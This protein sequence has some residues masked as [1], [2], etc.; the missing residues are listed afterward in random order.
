MVTR[1]RETEARGQKAVTDQE[2]VPPLVQVVLCQA[3]STLGTR[4]GAGCTMGKAGFTMARMDHWK[5]STS[6]DSVFVAL[7]GLYAAV[8]VV[9]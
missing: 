5:G 6:L 8:V 1:K 2:T 4:Q 9:E 3:S 7:A